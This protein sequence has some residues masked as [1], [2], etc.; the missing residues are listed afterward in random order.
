MALPTW[1]NALHSWHS[2]QTCPSPALNTPEQ[3]LPV[4]ALL[5]RV[6]T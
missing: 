6:F 3:R 1:P 2:T 5:Q 4:T